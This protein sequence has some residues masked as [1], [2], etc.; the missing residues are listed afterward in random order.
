MKY[1]NPVVKYINR[2]TGVVSSR[3]HEVIR[4]NDVV[5]INT[6]PKLS[7]KRKKGQNLFGD[8]NSNFF[9]E[10]GLLNYKKYIDGVLPGV[11][12]TYN[13]IEQIGYEKYLTK[14][15]DILEESIIHFW[16]SSKYNIVLHTSGYDSRVLSAIL[17]KIYQERGDVWLGKIFFACWGPEG[18]LFKDI[19]KY[20]GWEDD[21]LLLIDRT[22]DDYY[23]FSN[24]NF[25]KISSVVNG[26]N[27]VMS[28][29][30]LYIQD[31]VVNNISINKNIDKK[32]IVF[33]SAGFFNEIFEWFMPRSRKQNRQIVDV[34]L[35]QAYGSLY[36]QM[37]GTLE[38][39]IIYPLLTDEMFRFLTQSF[40]KY[41]ENNIREDIVKKLDYKLFS[42]FKRMD[43]RLTTAR[44][45]DKKIS[46][47]IYD[48][49]NN[50]W[51]CKKVKPRGIIKPPSKIYNNRLTWY[52]WTASSLLRYMISKKCKI[53]I[54]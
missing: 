8:G 15:L 27:S 25:Q 16:D 24:L 2:K 9:K 52:N 26:V 51:Y 1:L 35:E 45:L 12:K 28:N 48:T 54:K 14:I 50:S 13:K 40:S 19:F 39:P 6:D 7:H 36:S 41:S 5:T 21:T 22:G 32:N 38:Y 20:E 49:Y 46:K 47:Y 34:F 23:S 10:I 30:M 4:D 53:F 11:C 29:K 18:E 3:I 37:L 43:D 42:D 17:K 33:W 31:R 44:L